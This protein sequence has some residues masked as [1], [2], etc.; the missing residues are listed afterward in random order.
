MG[1]LL[2][3]I[4][5][6]YYFSYS[7]VKIVE[8][9]NGPKCVLVAL[10]NIIERDGVIE[11]DGNCSFE[12]ED[13]DNINLQQKLIKLQIERYINVCYCYYP[14]IFPFVYY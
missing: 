4:V 8:M 3:V 10:S 5:I 13:E 1:V 9:Y 14:L 7:T 11:R 12:K 2:I 6:K